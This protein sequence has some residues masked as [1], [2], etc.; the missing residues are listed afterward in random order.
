MRLC[1]KFEIGII[2]HLENKF[3]SG[4]YLKY[5]CDVK[6][7]LFRNKVEISQGEAIFFGQKIFYQVFLYFSNI[8]ILEFYSKINLRIPLVLNL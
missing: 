1:R 2:K 4:R 5:I 3:I 6:L 8:I 7:I